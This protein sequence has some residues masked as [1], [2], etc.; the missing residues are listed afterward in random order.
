MFTY[1][2]YGTLLGKSDYA[3]LEYEYVVSGGITP[4]PKRNPN[5]MRRYKGGNFREMNK[6]FGVIKWDTGLHCQSIKPR[7]KRSCELCIE[8]VSR[9]ELMIPEKERVVHRLVSKQK[10][11]NY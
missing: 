8:G 5:A 10:G 11:S 1:I 2:I 6:T 7:Y 4:E 3:V 9:W